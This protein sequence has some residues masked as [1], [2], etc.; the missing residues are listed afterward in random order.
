MYFKRHC[1]FATSCLRA[2]F[3]V[4]A[5]VSGWCS[6]PAI[7]AFRCFWE[8]TWNDHLITRS[9]YLSSQLVAKLFVSSS[10]L[11]KNLKKSTIILYF[12]HSAIVAQPQQGR[13]QLPSPLNQSGWVAS[14]ATQRA[15]V[16]E[17]VQ[18][19]RSWWWSKCSVSFCK[20]I[21]K[22][23]NP[24]FNN[25]LSIIRT[26][27]W[28]MWFWCRHIINYSQWI[29]FHALCKLLTPCI[30]TTFFSLSRL[31]FLYDK[32]T[33]YSA[34]GDTLRP[35][36][37]DY[38]PYYPSQLSNWLVC[39]IKGKNVQPNRFNFMH[40][41]FLLQVG[42][43]ARRQIVLTG[44]IS[45]VGLTPPL[46]LTLGCWLWKGHEIVSLMHSR[47]IQFVHGSFQFLEKLGEV[48]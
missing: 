37:Y 19:G 9:P 24:Y 13:S 32:L 38:K 14:C 8:V 27:E 40:V 15:I 35:A 16:S 4:P 17:S 2:S 25:L 43:H 20:R 18:H 41:F 21:K 48:A 39:L 44:P 1:F 28:F 29:K 12:K 23:S 26:W 22:L 36:L 42:N 46:T 3:S 11:E 47:F 34:A 33:C 6:Q 5:L 45:P 31:L 7:L 30:A 10:R